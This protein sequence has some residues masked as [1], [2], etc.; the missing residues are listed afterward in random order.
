MRI[1]A[2]AGPYTKYQILIKS[3]KKNVHFNYILEFAKS[4]NAWKGSF[5]GRIYL[6]ERT[7]TQ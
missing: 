2:L 3:F 6:M 5:T 4:E 7:L 1:K